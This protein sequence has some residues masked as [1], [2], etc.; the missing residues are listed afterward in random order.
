MAVSLAAPASAD[1]TQ[2]QLENPAPENWLHALGNYSSWSYSALNQITRDNVGDLRVISAI[3]ISRALQGTNSPSL[4]NRPLVID[5][6]MYINDIW[7]NIYGVDIADPANPR[8][9]WITDPA[10]DK[11]AP[12]GILTTRGIAAYGNMIYANLVDGRLIG[13]DMNTGELLIDQQIARTEADWDYDAVEGFSAAPLAVD[14]MILMGQSMGDWGTRGWLAAAD[15]T[16]GAQIWRTY[17]VPGPG[18]PGHETWADAAGTAWRT[19]GGAMW[20]TGSYDPETRLT[21]W[22]TANPVPMFDPEF[23]PGDNLYTNS[24]IAFNVDD[25]TIAWYFQYTPNESWDYDEIGV[26]TL[27]DVMVDGVLTKS[28]VHYGRNG[29]YYRLDRTNGT[30]ISATQWVDTVNWTAGIDAKTGLPVEYDPNLTLQTYRVETRGTR[31]GLP[32]F[33]FCPTATGGV[34]WQPTAYDP[35]TGLNYVSGMDGCSNITI[36]PAEPVAGGGNPNGVGQVWLGG[37]FNPTRGHTQAEPEG[38]IA[39]IDVNTGEIVH[40]LNMRYQS[41]SGLVATAGGLLFH[42]GYDGRITAHD[43]TTLE[44]LWAFSTGIRIKAAPM[45]FGVNGQQYVAVI[46]G[47]GGGAGGYPELSGLQPGATLYIFGL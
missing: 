5:G 43:S 44:E 23:R 6:K 37:Q 4:E 9:L 20:Q 40:T 38:I 12:R 10:M 22:G 3:P 11:E 16:T 46:A 7:G 15:A 45:S 18:E 8:V 29:F 30:F 39:A 14:G 35:E 47:G 25:G 13:V 34:R 42:G 26:H 41:Q 17:T 19:G 36:Q 32:T 24:A 21:I 31:A 1:V 2:A 27:V 28:V 33:D